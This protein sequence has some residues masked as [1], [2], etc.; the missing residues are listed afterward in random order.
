M[1]FNRW[2]SGEDRGQETITL[3][4]FPV[5]AHRYPLLQEDRYHVVP[6]AWFLG[7]IKLSHKHRAPTTQNPHPDPKKIIE[8]IVELQPEFTFGGFENGAPILQQRQEILQGQADEV[9]LPVTMINLNSGVTYLPMVPFP[10]VAPSATAQRPPAP[11]RDPS[12]TR[13]ATPL[14]KR[15][16]E[17][18]PGKLRRAKNQRHIPSEEDRRQSRLIIGPSRKISVVPPPP[19]EHTW[20]ATGI[21]TVTG[22]QT[23]PAVQ[24][25]P[26]ENITAAQPLEPPPYPGEPEPQR[27]PTEGRTHL[28]TV[29]PRFIMPKPSEQEVEEIRRQQ[30]AAALESL[31]R[32]SGPYR[33]ADGTITTVRSIIPTPERPTT[34]LVGTHSMAQPSVTTAVTCSASHGLQITVSPFG[35]SP[36][37]GQQHATVE[38]PD[39]TG[40]IPES[41]DGPP[42][43]DPAM[44]RRQRILINQRKLA[45]L[46]AKETAA[47]IAQVPDRVKQEQLEARQRVKQ[48][49][50]QSGVTLAQIRQEV[51]R[52][53]VE[54]N[55]NLSF[56]L[57]KVGTTSREDMPAMVTAHSSTLDETNELDFPKDYAKPE[58]LETLP[59]QETLPLKLKLPEPQDFRQPS[60][61]AKQSTSPVK[62]KIEKVSGKYTV[63]QGPYQPLNLKDETDV[64]LVTISSD[65]E[66]T[67]GDGEREETKGA[68]G[69]QL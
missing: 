42:V 26:A 32:F 1:T 14:S 6:A 66:E 52:R 28:S 17:G 22:D 8:M 12:T 40:H 37:T 44:T 23:L 41:A 43:N 4:K 33:A 27:T 36:H 46:R 57:P 20:T 61:S 11:R 38:L 18:S 45:Q 25:T 48:E 60:T 47:R 67:E 50:N 56:P 21:P 51:I 58:N 65:E 3:G 31:E 30:H 53:L 69:A 34:N 7:S 55:E 10:T 2:Y 49:A 15:K 64:T 35:A 39:N 68:R 16:A 13:P 19:A 62:I 63:K 54:G 5:M 24:N 29:Q 9:K 59:G